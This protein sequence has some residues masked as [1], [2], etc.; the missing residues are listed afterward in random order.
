MREA[1]ASAQVIIDGLYY[2]IGIHGF[3]F[4]HNGEEWVKSVRP[5]ELVIAEIQKKKK[6][7]FTA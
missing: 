7:V 4:Y 3:A 2:K 5:T 1:P 6:T